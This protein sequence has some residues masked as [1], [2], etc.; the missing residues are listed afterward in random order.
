VAIQSRK[1]HAEDIRHIARWRAIA[2]QSKR[3]PFLFGSEQA[4]ATANPATLPSGL[5]PCDRSFPDQRTLHARKRSEDRENR[6]QFR[7]ARV[8]GLRQRP[9]TNPTNFKGLDR[10]DQMTKAAAQ[11]VEFPHDHDIAGP[12]EV[13]SF[14]HPRTIRAGTG[15]SIS[16][17]ALAACRAQRIHLKVKVLIRSRDTSISYKHCSSIIIKTR[18]IIA[19]PLVYY[20]NYF[21]ESELPCIPLLLLLAELIIQYDLF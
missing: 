2:E 4:R 21:R 10:L 14:P 15:C 5:Q 3:R 19:E 20:E 12:G 18:E 7:A 17:D 1:R 6:A 16:E 8:Q 9:E 11:P 13:E